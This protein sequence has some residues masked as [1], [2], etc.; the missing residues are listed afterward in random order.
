MHK[1]ARTGLA[2]AAATT[3]VLAA[4]GITSAPAH[5]AEGD[6]VENRVLVVAVDFKDAEHADADAVKENARKEYFGGSESIA[7]YYTK[8]SQGAFTY[9]PAA[10]DEVVGPYAL[11]LPQNPC[12]ASAVMKAA[13]EAVLA[14]GYT[15]KED[16]DSISVLQPSA[17]SECSWAGLGSVPGPNTW[18]QVGEESKVSKGAMVHE[19][20]HN[21]GF[22]HHERDE[23]P[24]GDLGRCTEGEG[25]SRKT[26][27][28]AGG[29]GVGFAA[30]ELI[31]KGWLPD[32]QAVTVTESATFT[33]S[34]LYGGKAGGVRALDIPLGKSRLVVEYR[35]EDPTHTDGDDG[36]LDA[37]IEGVHAYLVPEGDYDHSRLVDPTPGETGGTG[38]E[39]AITSLTDTANKVR[40]DVGRSGDGSATVSVSL[41]GV[42]APEAARSSAQGITATPAPQTRT[43]TGEGAPV[44]EKGTDAE[45]PAAPDHRAKTDGAAT[46]NLAETGAGSTTPLIAG[47][48]AV[49][50]AA[51][52]LCLYALR[53][54][55]RRSA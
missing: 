30:P 29:P 10:K 38:K 21:Q 4:S 54:R 7:S 20:G 11:D 18:L 51:G 42:P 3:A 35:H 8:V 12:D 32:G 33:L 43:Q 41:D 46:Q 40:V 1:R 6:P 5:A 19:F 22:G 39:D 25:H 24:G 44:D 28:G 52:A 23:C 53:R 45:A 47:A 2:T 16:Y 9:V 17:G 15:E 26:P 31:S 36:N 37:A 48:G 34:P 55:G 27:M 14:D 13:K 50:A 49:L